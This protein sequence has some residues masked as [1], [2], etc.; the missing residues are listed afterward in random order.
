ML[1]RIIQKEIVHNVLSFRFI[2]TYALLFCLVLLALFL[3]T[4]DYRTRMQDYTTET[5]KE[6]DRLGEIESIEDPSEQY[7][8]YSNTIFSGVRSPKTLS[9]LAR[10]LESSLPTWVSSGSWFTPHSSEDR[11]GKKT[12]QV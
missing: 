1:F 4:I 3:M 7:E 10:G 6:R 12:S 2:I 8:E 9:I 11:L 5:G